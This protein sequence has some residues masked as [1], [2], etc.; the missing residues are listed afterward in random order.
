MERRTSR[1]WYVIT[2]RAERG[3]SFL[4]CI[5]SGFEIQGMVFLCAA[6]EAKPDVSSI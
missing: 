1:V 6:L 2:N 3:L 4:I 5:K